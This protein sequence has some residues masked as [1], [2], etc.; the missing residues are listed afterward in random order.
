M[1]KANK[2]TISKWIGLKNGIPS[3][4]ERWIGDKNMGREVMKRVKGNA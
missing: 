1:K 2:T 4:I 3:K